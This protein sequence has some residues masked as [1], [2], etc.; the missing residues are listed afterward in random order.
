M[1][2]GP[3]EEF[4]YHAFFQAVRE[5]VWSFPF[6][7]GD[8]SADLGD[9]AY[10]GLAFYVNAG[11]VEDRSD[12]LA[13][14]RQAR[15][16][17]LTVIRAANDDVSY[18]MNNLEEGL[19]AELGLIE[20]MAVTGDDNGIQHVDA[21]LDN[22]NG[23]VESMGPYLEIDVD[24]WALKTYGP[25]TIT[26]VVALM[27]LRYA[28]LL[29]NDRAAERLEFGT[30]LVAVIDEKVWTGTFYRFSTTIERVDLYPNVMMIIA[31]AVAYRLTGDEAYRT[32]C[33]AVYEAIQ[34][35]KY[36]F[37][38]GYYSQYSAEAM[39]AKTDDYTTLSSQN[40]AIMAMAML[41]DITGDPK[42]KTEIVDLVS[43]IHDKLWVDERLL[44][45]WMDGRVAIP[46]DLEYFCS[47]CNLQFLY[48][49]W[50]VES[51]LYGR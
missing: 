42:F 3:K 37:R 32:K 22:V 31:D 24:S 1:D 50:Y 2:T 47:G 8:W 11:K 36:D 4:P 17:N 12:H 23:L 10:Y 30:K 7:D 18:L 27:N 14:A 15:Q 20:Y 38:K 35:L 33:L 5:S 40:Y 49:I 21:F 45:H 16:R 46:E 26:G 41:F 43:F 28:E 25:T 51:Q 34:L 48:V 44:H 9:A 39:G 19:M 13:R 29:K 6:E